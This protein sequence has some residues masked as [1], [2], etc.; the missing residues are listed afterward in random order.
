MIAPGGWQQAHRS[1]GPLMDIVVPSYESDRSDHENTRATGFLATE[2]EEY[3]AAMAT[4]LTLPEATK[5][6]MR[7][8]GRS[9]ASECFSEELFDRRFRACIEPLL[10]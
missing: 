9:H 8:Q 10:R 4:V 1:A 7:A 5:G 2:P 6:R 3:A